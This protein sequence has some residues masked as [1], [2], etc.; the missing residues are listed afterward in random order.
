MTVMNVQGVIIALNR[1]GT[2]LNI[3]TENYQWLVRSLLRPSCSRLAAASTHTRAL[4]YRR[5]HTP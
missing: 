4:V 5:Q 1:I 3:P 2:D